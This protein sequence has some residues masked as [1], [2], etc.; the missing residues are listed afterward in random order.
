VDD[1]VTTEATFCPNCGTRQAPSAEFCVACGQRQPR[2]LGPD[3]TAVHVA[4]Q[5]L[6]AVPAAPRPADGSS[7]ARFSLPQLVALVVGASVAAGALAVAMTLVLSRGDPPP[8]DGGDPP[9]TADL[10]V[11]ETANIRAQVPIAW[12]VVTRARDTIVVEDP[13]SRAMWLR[14]A[15]VPAVLTLDQV[16]E[17][18]LDHAR[19]QAPDA[20][21]CAGPET[22][23]VPGGPLDGRFF[24][25]CSTFIPQG[26]GPAVRLTDAYYVGIWGGS[27]VSV[28]QLTAVPNA[29]EAFATEVRG[30]PPPEWKLHR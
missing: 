13:A 5:P 2:R 24:V 19:D 8:P 1:L 26:G 22:A 12:D 16:Q 11:V 9:V 4:G 20:R 29:L 23:A 27:T 3:H 6:P 30:L 15:T 25:V 17:R 21:V 7:G 18:F 14:S 28:M 10:E